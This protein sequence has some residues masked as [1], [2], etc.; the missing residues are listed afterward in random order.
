MIR[1]TL[2]FALLLAG[3]LIAGCGGSDAPRDVTV[4]IASSGGN[5]DGD[6]T[7]DPLFADYAS[8]TQANFDNVFVGTEPNPDGGYS[9]DP[10]YDLEHRGYL[11]FPVD[12][13]PF[14]AHITQ[15]TVT[16]RILEVAPLTGTSVTLWPDLVH[17]TSIPASSNQTGLAAMFDRSDL[18]VILA[19][20][21]R[22]V[23]AGSPRDISIDVT[24]ALV[25][26]GNL[27][28]STMQLRLIGTHGRIVVDDLDL[29]PLLTVTYH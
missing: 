24:D 11:T 26:A 5:L 15:A 12:G 21:S 3:L 29:L 22:T 17:F 28:Y 16:L 6:I 7:Y 13:I 27:G 8:A 23:A 18:T 2:G 4:D 19:G 1:K 14:G 25:R 20:P 9:A 10:A